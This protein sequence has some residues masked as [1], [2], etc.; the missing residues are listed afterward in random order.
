[1]S[2]LCHPEANVSSANGCLKGGHGGGGGV[3]FVWSAQGRLS[4]LSKWTSALDDYGPGRAN[5]TMSLFSDFPLTFSA[6][7]SAGKPPHFTVTEVSQEP[8]C[9]PFVLADVAQW[10]A[11]L[12]FQQ[13]PRRTQGP[14]GALMWPLQVRAPGLGELG[15][16][17][18]LAAQWV[19]TRPP[20]GYL[21]NTGSQKGFWH[22]WH[23]FLSESRTELPFNFIC[24]KKEKLRIPA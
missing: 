18:L 9:H 15:F 6:E 21:T 20:F 8:A 13:A 24:K 17:C 3:Q 12:G 23:S 2:P 7:W 19:W 4:F 22:I 16:V 5:S 11:A 10:L 14:P 1:M